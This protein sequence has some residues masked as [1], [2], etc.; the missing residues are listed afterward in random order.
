MVDKRF[1]H[2]L[3]GGRIVYVCMCVY[4][5]LYVCV[6]VRVFRKINLSI[7]TSFLTVFENELGQ[8]FF[9]LHRYVLEFLLPYCTRAR[10]SIVFHIIVGS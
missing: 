3:L 6:C 10:A 1:R 8:F 2:L 7:F 5:Y 9:L 4:V